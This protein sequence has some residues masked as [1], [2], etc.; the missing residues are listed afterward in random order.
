MEINDLLFHVIALT[1]LIYAKLNVFC[2]KMISV[3][4]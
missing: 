2:L 1:C 4:F 3:L